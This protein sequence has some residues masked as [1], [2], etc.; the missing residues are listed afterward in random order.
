MLQA[1]SCIFHFD[2]SIFRPLVALVATT[3]RANHKPIDRK[4]WR[5]PRWRAGEK[6][7]GSASEVEGV[8]V[9]AGNHP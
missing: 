9:S 8:A 5:I 7:T 4:A 3:E 2:R 1:P 6:E